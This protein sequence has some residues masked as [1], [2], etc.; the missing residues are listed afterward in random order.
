MVDRV[1]EHP[2]RVRLIPVPGEDNLYDLVRE[3]GATVEGTPLCKATMLPD[4][5]CNTLGLNTKTAEPKDAFLLCGDRIGDIKTTTRKGLGSNWLLC[6]GATIQASAY[7]ELAQMLGGPF[8]GTWKNYQIATTTTNFCRAMLYGNGYYVIG[9]TA[10]NYPMIAYT[11]NPNGAWSTRQISNTAFDVYSMVYADGYF[12]VCGYGSKSTYILYA[13]SPSI[14]WTLKQIAS[15]ETNIAYLTYGNGKFVACGGDASGHPRAAYAVHPG[16]TWT[17]VNAYSG[18]VDISCANFM[19]GQFCMFGNQYRSTIEAAIYSSDGIS[20]G[21]RSIRSDRN[22]APC[23]A[24]Y[25]NGYYIVALNSEIL[26]STSLTG[27]WTVKKVAEYT[28]L[29]GIGCGSG[30]FFAVG[31]RGKC[32]YATSPSGVWTEITAYADADLWKIQYLNGYFITCGITSSYY[33]V[34]ASLL[35]GRVL[36][37]ISPSHA[38][39]YIRAK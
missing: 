7:P 20:W 38:Y 37:T 9:Y 31:D 36:P 2:G 24:V 15:S 4:D 32:F 18:Q 33:P 10:N 1:P 21:Y 16:D 39:A 34:V 30:Y 11:T 23:G 22:D 13:T 26:Y 35:D 14:S 25:A 3:D 12:V 27:T 5:V 29:R 6:N 19:N 17:L 28:P 8:E